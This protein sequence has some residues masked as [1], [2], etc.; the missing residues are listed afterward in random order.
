MK[1]IRF[2]LLILIII[3]LGLIATQSLWVPNVVSLILQSETPAQTQPLAEFDA[4][5]ST[6]TVED[7]PVTLIKGESKVPAAPGAASM[8]TTRYFGNEVQI[9]KGS[10]TTTRHCLYDAFEAILR[11]YERPGGAEFTYSYCPGSYYLF[12]VFGVVFCSTLLSGLLLARR[13][14]RLVLRAH[15]P[16]PMRHGQGECRRRRRP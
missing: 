2:F 3:G 5:N 15:C 7:K 10:V 13:Q 16:R 4:K 8:I 6:F 9:E 12:R 1:A 11:I 14:S